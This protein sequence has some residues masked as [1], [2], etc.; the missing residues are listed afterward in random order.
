M[1]IDNNP[2]FIVGAA[3]S[4]TTLLQYMLRSHP[5]LSLPTGES[6]FFIP[7]Y[8][9]RNEFGDLS[10]ITRLRELVNELYQFNPDF[11]DEELH[12]IQ[13]NVESITQQLH[14]LEIKSI[15]EVFSGIFQINAEAEGKPRWGDK[16]P[17]YVLHLDTIVEMFPKALIVHLIRDGRDCA[18]SMLERKWDLKIFNI[19]HAA[20][21]WNKYILAGESFGQKHP[22]CYYKIYYEDILN[23]PEKT[24]MNL[25]QFLNINF[26]TQVINFKKSGDS[27]DTPLVSQPIQKSNQNKWKKKMTPAQIRIFESLAGDTL[28]KCSYETIYTEPTINRF[29][30]FINEL[31]IKLCQFY[32]KHFMN[33][34]K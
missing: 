1:G 17:Y 26:N 15:P 23:S 30:W 19:Y 29:E 11:F 28:R 18:L 4:G 21:T 33:N 2:I 22:E 8:Q 10:D 3:R 13:F 32:C 25:C 27:G 14:K 16:T 34:K 20:Y 31:H 24:L 5:E 9:R 12:G 7:F 6:H